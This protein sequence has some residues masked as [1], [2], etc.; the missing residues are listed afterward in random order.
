MSDDIARPIPKERRDGVAVTSTAIHAAF[1]RSTY[2]QA[3]EVA[4]SMIANG[5][6][7][8]ALSAKQECFAIA[9]SEGSNPTEAYRYAYNVSD[10]PSQLSAKAREVLQRPHV[11]NRVRELNAQKEHKLLRDRDKTQRYVIDNLQK[12]IELPGT[13]HS[14]RVHA[15]AMLG[16]LSGLFD[17]STNGANAGADKKN[18]AEVERE[19]REKLS[20]LLGQDAKQV[21]GL[22]VVEH[23]QAQVIANNPGESGVDSAPISEERQGEM[24][25]GG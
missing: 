23:D 7:F 2:D 3:I 6:P 10:V 9:I 22:A 25:G 15:L 11:A 1:P 14:A 24:G 12:I 16:K 5:Q 19:L 18:A 4:D 13:H 21:K 8:K 20:A 17:G